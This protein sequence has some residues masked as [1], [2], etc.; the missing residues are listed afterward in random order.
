MPPPD[1][2]GARD[3]AHV[4][5]AVLQERAD[6]RF[7]S[8]SQSRKPLRDNYAVHATS[9]IDQLTRALGALPDPAARLALDGIKPGTLV[10]FATAPPEEGSRKTA[11]K[12][13]TAL[14]FPAQD[15]VVLRGGRREDKSE[16]ALVF[17]PDDARDFL[18][19]RIAEYG[20]ANLGNRKR[21]DVERFE[22]IETVS[23]AE[24]RALFSG[25][26][27]FASPERRWWELWVRE[28]ASPER[29]IA[30]SIGRL[31]ASAGLDVHA[32]RLL[33]PDTTVVFVH[34]TAEALAAFA[35]RLPGGITEIRRAT[36]TISTFLDEGGREGIGQHDWVV[37]L[38][39]RLGPA[40]ANAPAVCTLD[41]GIAAAHPLLAP[42][43]A[44]AWAY[45]TAWGADD[46]YPHGGHG[47][48]L[49]GLALLGDLAPLMEDDRAVGLTHVIESMKL[50]PPPGFPRTDPGNYGVVTQGAVAAVE[51]VRPDV[52]RAF[53]LACSTQDFPNDRPSSW[54]G[55]IDQ[56]VSGSMPGE[57]DSAMSA[58]EH[59]KRLMVVA[60]GNMDGGRRA[61][62]MRCHPLEDPAQ[63]WNAITIGGVTTKETCNEAG[64][65]PVV[66]A[67][68]R[69][70]FSRGS[71]LQPND[72]TPIK[73]ELL[74]EAGNMAADAMGFC[75]WHPD[76][77][78][79]AMGSD[80][81]TEPLV[82][83]WA[84]S[85]A[86]GL[87][88]H[89]FGRLQAEMPERWPETLRALAVDSAVWPEPIRKRLIG[90]G[91]HW[92]SL[93]KA[94]LQAILREVGYGVPR[95]DRAM[96]SARN[97]VA[98]VAEAE[99][100][101]FALGT[102][103]RTAV[104]ND[105]HFY[106]LPWPKRVLEEL[107]NEVVTMKVTLSYFIEPNLTG[108]AAT[109][110]ESYRSFGLRFAMKKRN[111]TSAKFRSR[112]SAATE[113][114]PAES[115]SEKS[116]WLLGPKSIQAGSLHCDLWR[117]R[118]IDL[119]LHD[120]IAVYPVGG[121]WKSHVG[122]RRMTDKGR[123]ALVISLSAPGHAVDLHA[124]VVSLVDA[125]IVA[126]EAR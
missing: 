78:M 54:S 122:Q 25:T 11:V 95:I 126:V 57:R 23:V 14:E 61:D 118:A 20:A 84:T 6:Y 51:I 37:E 33:F 7:P 98:M 10:E 68:H 115:E 102:D 77:S 21:P 91:A 125:A 32:D 48:A 69:S 87:A 83:F 26:V 27:D 3:R 53:C 116:C 97:D 60:T 96:L 52:N 28:V 5:I 86:S 15:I 34:A 120:E 121:W 46:H 36:G 103:G 108:R 42:G 9:L 44:G 2:F 49:A 50:L 99:L 17:V 101:P 100:Q 123:Y 65:E 74:F 41:T 119:A 79:L 35:A 18:Q 75:D 104:F 89:F 114:E 88:G 81:V 38:S 66:P 58:A 110:P 59:P 94:E 13:P 117:G 8:R 45:D 40:P 56:I 43:L 24:A 19:R 70:P 109:R 92:R 62:V 124:E 1:E 82:P 22:A 93:S 112:I 47:T 76:L 113:R 39:A 107:E 16:S 111:E 12:V 67:N 73:P 85:A 72:L 90:R 80:V 106:K 55:A 71:N 30:D 29:T 31:A 63:S 4:D 105:M 64:F